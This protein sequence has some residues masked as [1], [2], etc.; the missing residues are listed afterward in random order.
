MISLIRLKKGQET[1]PLPKTWCQPYRLAEHQSTILTSQKAD[2]LESKLAIVT[3]AIPYSYSFSCISLM[4]NMWSLEEWFGSSL[5]WFSAIFLSCIVITYYISV[6]YHP[7]FVSDIKQWYTSV[8]EILKL[9]HFFCTKVMWFQFIWS[10]EMEILLT[11]VSIIFF[12][13]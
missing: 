9:F 13:N 2:G 3:T 6:I 8:V 7:Y 11:A 1:P 10:L 4:I 12:C 5:H